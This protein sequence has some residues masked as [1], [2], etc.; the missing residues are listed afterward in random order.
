M[1]NETTRTTANDALIA[2]AINAKVAHGVRAKTVM[3]PLVYTKA[4]NP[5]MSQIAETFARWDALS[6]ASDITAM[7]EGTD[8]SNV[9]VSQSG[10]TITAALKGVLVKPTDIVRSTSVYGMDPTPWVEQIS[11]LL[12]DKIDLDLCALLGGFSSSVGSTGADLTVNQFLTAAYTL[13]NANAPDG[14]NPSDA[15][16]FGGTP[17]GIAKAVAV[18]HPIQVFDLQAAVAASGAAWLGADGAADILYADG[19]KPRGYV[20]TLFGIPVF[21]STNVPTANVGADRAGGMF[22]PASLGLLVKWMSRVRFDEDISMGAT[23]IVGDAFY[24]VG[25][26]LDAGGVAIVT[27]A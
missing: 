17:S 4:L 18:L 15:E 11:R 1:A 6:A 13:R 9:A 19:S 7:S 21:E 3:G 14:F 2:T 12:A 5:E 20:G 27:D 16:V 22:V 10:V 23:E 25:E 24:G 8:L 26:L